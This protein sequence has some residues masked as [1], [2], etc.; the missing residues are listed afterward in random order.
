M[1]VREATIEK[2]NV[3]LVIKGIMVRVETPRSTIYLIQRLLWPRWMLMSG[4]CPSPH[5]L[6]QAEPLL[7]HVD[8]G[9]G[10]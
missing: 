7:L 10:R 1:E 6:S 9:Q 5:G 3:G 2:V 4:P 8:T